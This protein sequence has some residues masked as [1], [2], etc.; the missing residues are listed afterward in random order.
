MPYAEDALIES[1]MAA[2]I[3]EA[4]RWLEQFPSIRVPL[5]AVIQS[6]DFHATKHFICTDCKLTDDDIGDYFEKFNGS[7]R[8]IDVWHW[9]VES[10]GL[11]FDAKEWQQRFYRQADPPSVFCPRSTRC[12]INPSTWKFLI[13]LGFTPTKEDFEKTMKRFSV[14]ALEYLEQNFPEFIDPDQI[15]LALMTENLPLLKFY[16]RKFPQE[17]VD[18]VTS[19]TIKSFVD[20]QSV[21]MLD[22]L[23]EK[24]P[25]VFD[26]D[27]LF[28]A[29]LSKLPTWSTDFSDFSEFQWLVDHGARLDVQMYFIALK[30]CLPSKWFLLL[31]DNKV[32]ATQEVLHAWQRSAFYNG[33]GE[34]SRETSG[35]RDILIAA[36]RL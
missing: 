21:H 8:Q 36:M 30:N 9:F 6:V 2:R 24:A 32:K 15:P 1:V 35:V 20:M 34:S 12:D 18:A 4:H 19:D 25:Q 22:Y 31:Y 17:A 29:S 26:M 27:G 5:S 7:Q 16:F 13:S 23:F 10:L 14:A 28:M 33:R 3:D 11:V